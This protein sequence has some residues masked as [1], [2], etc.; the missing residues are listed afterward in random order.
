MKKLIYSVIAFAAVAVGCTKSEMIETPDFGGQAI[1]FDTYIGK[2]PTTKAQSVDLAY[3][4][5]ANKGFHVSAFMHDQ[6]AVPAP[7]SITDPYMDK[8][9][10]WEGAANETNIPNE[11]AT[12]KV[13]FATQ[14]GDS[15]PSAPSITAAT[16]DAFACPTGWS[17]FPTSE[18]THYVVCTTMHLLKE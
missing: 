2:V 6:N 17:D 18:S 14:T 5:D 9:V 8:D 11:T 15:A 12:T 16:Y 4:Q 7:A 3:L 10:W 13:I 1:T